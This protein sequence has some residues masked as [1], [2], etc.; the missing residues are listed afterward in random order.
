MRD[1]ETPVEFDDPAIAMAHRSAVRSIERV[2]HETVVPPDQRIAM[3]HIV[4]QLA[5]PK[6]LIITGAGV[7]TASGIPDYRSKNGRLTT[8]R[9]MTF[10]EFAHAP[11]HVRR[12]WARAFI[13]MQFMRAA[14]PNRTH[15]GLVEL[16]R[17]GLIAGIVTQNVDGLHTAAGSTNVIA[18][19]GDM[20]TVICLDCATLHPRS[21]I[22]ALLEAANPTFFN[23]V[24][25]KDDMVNP[26]GDVELRDSDVAR[27]TMISCPTCGGQR[28]KP[29][30]VYFGEN[31]PRQRRE[32]ANQWLARASGV[33]AIGTSLAVMSGYKF[34]LDA[35]AQG[36]PV[37][38]IN[39]GPGRADAKV[40]TVWRAD[41]GDAI[42]QILD[43]LEL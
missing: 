22:D 43:A 23:S 33:I 27:F 9:P 15:Y 28:L 30:V 7:S 26:D 21:R 42:D 13:G 40:D 38:V 4:R 5:T 16:E 6:T 19:H 20:D 41:V 18:L 3:N 2:V 37:A 39:G 25:V 32:Q 35:K 34:V 12:Y 11:H 36:K 1:G 31:V 24:R 29:N 14:Q 17:A 8:G 10:Q